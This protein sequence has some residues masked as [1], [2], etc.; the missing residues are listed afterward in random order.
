[1]EETAFDRAVARRQANEEVTDDPAKPRSRAPRTPL[2]PPPPGR[3]ESFKVEEAANARVTAG[4]LKQWI[5]EGLNHWRT[6]TPHGEAGPADIIILR[7][8]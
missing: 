1:L 6:S 2:P 3:Q 4:K 8:L 7:E 5:N